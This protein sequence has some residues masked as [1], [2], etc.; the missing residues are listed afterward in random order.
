M[1]LESYSPMQYISE[2]NETNWNDY[3]IYENLFDYASLLISMF[4]FSL[5]FMLIL[6]WDLPYAFEDLP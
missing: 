6:L 3:I 5:W 4:S 1:G 2:V